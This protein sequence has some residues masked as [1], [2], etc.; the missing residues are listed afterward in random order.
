[1]ARRNNRVHPYLLRGLVSC[2][3]CQHSCM[4][5]QRPPAYAYYL[6][7]TKAQRRDLA[8]GERCPA[9][10]ILARALE[11]LV[12]AD[13]CCVLEHPEMIAEAMERARGSHWLPQEWQARR[14]NLQR[15]RASLSQQI[16]RLT[17]A[18]LAG[19]VGLG[20]YERRRR[21][22]EAR[23]LALEQQEQ[24]L[25]ADAE[26][27]SETITLGAHADGFCQRVRDGLATADF[28]RKRA[29]LEL[30][31]DRVVVTDSAV[32]IRY[33][34][35]TSPEGERESFCRLRTDY[36][37]ALLAAQPSGRVR[38]LLRRAGRD[39]PDR[40]L[41]ADV[42][43][44]H[45]ARPCL[46]SRSQG[47]AGR[48]GAR[49]LPRGLLNQDPPQGRL[50]RPAPRLRPDRRRGERQPPLSGPARSRATNR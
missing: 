23:L 35:P 22:T 13:L 42:Q 33:I 43:L 39:K 31:V 14:A 50:R 6:C 26:R 37:E 2:G 38:G 44:Y 32:E 12:W 15:G 48:S 24:E 4:G 10:Y 30:L 8:P 49:A 40:S 41:G 34:F 11:E 28:E 16:E 19:I 9:R 27:Q 20:E 7:R 5:R 36:L 47:G 17:E 25:L 3:H 1:M 46:R 18:Y 29:L 45:R 21:E